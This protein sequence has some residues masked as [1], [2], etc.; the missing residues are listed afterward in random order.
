MPA[1]C[2]ERACL[3]TPGSRGSGAASMLSSMYRHDRW[4]STIAQNLP[5]ERGVRGGWVQVGTRHIALRCSVGGLFG[6]AAR[7]S[8]PCAAPSTPTCRARTK[9]PPTGAGL[10][11]ERRR[12][13]ARHVRRCAAGHRWPV[14]PGA[15]N[16]V[17]PLWDQPRYVS[18]PRR[19]RGTISS[20]AGSRR[21]RPSHPAR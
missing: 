17:G 18:P 6:L 9:G 8:I 19:G 21:Y 12:P 11:P 16:G 2:Q 7:S 20:W 13:C 15:E 5:G 14:R 10:S 1:L 4:S 3:R